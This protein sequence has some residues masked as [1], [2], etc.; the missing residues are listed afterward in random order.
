MHTGE[1]YFYYARIPTTAAKTRCLTNIIVRDLLIRRKDEIHETKNLS[2][3]ILNSFTVHCYIRFRNIRYNE[4][5]FAL[6]L[7][8]SL[9]LTLLVRHDR[10][11]SVD[12]D[13]LL[14]LDRFH[15][16]DSSLESADLDRNLLE[17]LIDMGDYPCLALCYQILDVKEG[18]RLR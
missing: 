8:R 6:L 15:F 7:V 5:V 9:D 11:D 18:K 14:S 10:L 13:L 3:I 17:L 2:L 1:S 12:V 4:I 16:R